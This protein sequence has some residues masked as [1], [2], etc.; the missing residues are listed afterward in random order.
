M[1]VQTTYKA[2][3]IARRLLL[4]QKQC[5]IA[6][7]LGLGEPTVSKIVNSPLFLVIMSQLQKVEDK[8]AFEVVDFMR[9]HAEEAA[10][11]TV[12]IM[13]DPNTNQATRLN[14]SQHVLRLGGYGVTKPDTTI[15]FNSLTFEQRLEASENGLDVEFE[16]LSST[17]GASPALGGE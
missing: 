13:R 8:K 12:D 2:R 4:G 9:E 5:D 3:E 16:E 6:E 10:L 14:A 1:A 15:N 11:T 7:D 17:K